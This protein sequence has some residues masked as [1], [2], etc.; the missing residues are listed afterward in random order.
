M[1]AARRIAATG[2]DEVFSLRGGIA[3]WA[4]EIEPD[5]RVV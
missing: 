3:A 5:L 1:A 4:D 2:H